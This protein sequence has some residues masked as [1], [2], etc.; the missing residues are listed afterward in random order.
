[1][2]LEEKSLKKHVKFQELNSV[3]IVNAG[4]GKEK[5][6]WTEPGRCRIK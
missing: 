3:K 5:M 4:R 1:M 2:F 6:G